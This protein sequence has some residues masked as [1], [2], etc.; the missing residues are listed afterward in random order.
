MRRKVSDS[1][2]ISD[3]KELGD[4]IR[5]VVSAHAGT[6]ERG[7]SPF[8]I[9]GPPV[10]CSDHASSGLALIIHELATNASKYGALKDAG[11]RIT[12]T[13]ETDEGIVSLQ[14]SETGGPIINSAPIKS[15]F[16]STLAQ[17]TVKQF[18]GVLT[19]EWRS[20]G[21]SITMILS[22]ARLAE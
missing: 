5:A 7:A 18:G 6:S 15:G 16:G 11:G 3:Q 21:L 9:E 19:R 12:I 1:G 4:I 14:W 17:R 22:I 8:H 20:E 10:S 13:W 2:A